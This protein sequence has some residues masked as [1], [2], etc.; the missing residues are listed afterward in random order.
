MLTVFLFLRHERRDDDDD[1]H[2]T[3]EATTAATTEFSEKGISQE[4]FAGNT[5]C[6]GKS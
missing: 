6:I 5:E 3:R 4:T 2:K 1:T